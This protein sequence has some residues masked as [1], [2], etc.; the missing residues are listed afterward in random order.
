MKTFQKLSSDQQNIDITKIFKVVNSDNNSL[1]SYRN[2]DL[3][4]I[5][6]DDK[7]S[8]PRFISL[9]WKISQF[10]YWSELYYADQKVIIQGPIRS[11][12]YILE[13][14]KQLTP[15]TKKSINLVILWISLKLFFKNRK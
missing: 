2:W 11:L 3:F 9:D 4:R 5:L 10:I 6:D 15:T 8:C 14:Y 13:I 12:Q 7:S 1:N